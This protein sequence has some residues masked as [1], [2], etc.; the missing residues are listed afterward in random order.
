[1]RFGY[2][3]LYVPEVLSTLSFYEQAFGLKRRFLDDA[4]RYGEL[5]TGATVLAFAS[6]TLAEE[7]GVRARPNRPTDDP[8]AVEIAFVTDD[9]EGAVSRALKAGAQPVKAP[10]RKPWG[11]VIAY[12]RDLNG[13]LVELCTP[14]GG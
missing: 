11:Q 9:I 3:I 13:V 14:M 12:V 4:G 7:N 2:T 5:E 10:T 6:E 1:M 8:P